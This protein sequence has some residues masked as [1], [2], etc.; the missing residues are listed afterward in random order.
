MYSKPAAQLVLTMAYL[1]SAAGAAASAQA[2]RPANLFANAGFELGRTGPWRLD[3][4]GKTSALLTIDGKDAFEGRRSALVAIDSVAEWGTQFGQSFEAG[5]KGKTCTF[6]VFAKGVAGNP[7]VTLEIERSAKPWDRAVRSEAFRLSAD[8]WTELHVTFKVEKDF[9]Q[10]W[11]AYISCRQATCRYRADMF[12]LY[13]GPHTPYEQTVRRRLAAA[14]VRLYD[15]G[16]PAGEPLSPDALSARAGWVALPP[17][18]V[19]HT[20]KGAAVFMND[21]I[22]VV[23][24]RKARGAEVYGRRKGGTALRAVL[25]PAAGAKL[26]SVTITKN[27]PTEV[28]LDAAFEVPAG[29][30]VTLGTALEI[31]QVFVATEPRAGL[32]ALCV[33]APCRFAVLPD[34]FADDIVADATRLPVARVDLPGEHFLLHMLTRG[35]A[36]VM[37]VWDVGGSDV[38]VALAGRG[39]ARTIRSAE[40]PYGK[41]GRIWVAVLEGPGIWHAREVARGEAGK[42]IPLD[43]R[44]PYPALWRVDWTRDDTLT[45]S[46][47]MVNQR[48]DG[49][50][51]KHTWLGTTTTLPADRKRWTTVLGR[52]Q[53]PCWLDTGG[54]GYLHPLRKVIRFDGPAILY[55]VDRVRQ[56][57]LDRFPV[58]DIMRRTLGVGPCEYI[59]D[60]ENQHSHSK[61]RATCSTRDELGRIYGRKEQKKRRAE[62]EKVLVEVMI[63]IRYIRGRIEGYVTFGHD[64]LD[65][66][67]RQAKAHPE[68][69]PRIAE[70]ETLTRAIDRYVAER[71]TRIKTPE[72]AAEMVEEFRKTLLT[73]DGP[74]APARVKKFTHAWVEIGGNQDELVGECR[75]AVKWVRQRAGLLMALEPRMAEIAREV[76]RRTQIILRNPAGHEAANH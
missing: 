6:A 42:V 24:R 10:G 74:D 9:A 20:F 54:R 22:A 57:P 30:T 62:I 14:G 38:R 44:A 4:D 32:A 39:E 58:V 15:T 28:A 66:L 1:L 61:G 23:L 52:F 37:S 12:R 40:I 2:P 63:F 17:G 75:M 34:F 46:W 41:G 70:L 59:L 56:T 48:S 3:T 11:F 45:G 51:T 43:W 50:F 7:T 69:A 60:V 65:Y 64:L 29:K 33:E 21:R 35:E 47:D 76:R 5:A 26:S 8:K 18:G 71:R 16:R 19:K 55:P 25:A 36:I 67:A 72:H 31:G 53:Y 49:L 73:Y 27:D 68:L 13:E